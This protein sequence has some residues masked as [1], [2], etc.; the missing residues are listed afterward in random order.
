LGIELLDFSVDYPGEDYQEYKRR[1]VRVH[2]PGLS[3]WIPKRDASYPVVDLSTFG[4]AFK[5][6][7]KSHRVEEG[8]LLDV[9]VQGKVWIAG[10]EAKIVA[11]R[12]DI[13]VACTFPNMSRLQEQR[14]DKLSLEIQK[15]WIRNRKL[16]KQQGEDE[17]NAK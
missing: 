16:Q 9:H 17:S 15:R 5:D 3:V 10:L 7:S 2:L 1:A 14:M 4:L 12:D 8:I 6:E 13:L 11:I